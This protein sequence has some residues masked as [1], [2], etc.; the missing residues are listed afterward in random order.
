MQLLYE[1]KTVSKRLVN[2][3]ENKYSIPGEDL[4]DAQTNL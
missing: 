1:I 2:D 4:S 3:Q